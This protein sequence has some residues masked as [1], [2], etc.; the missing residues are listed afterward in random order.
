[1]IGAAQKNVTATA[2]VKLDVSAGL[3]SR[4]QSWKC[5]VRKV[6]QRAGRLLAQEG[7]L[8]PRFD[9]RVLCPIVATTPYLHEPTRLGDQGRPIK[10]AWVFRVAMC[11]LL[12]SAS[13]NE[14][15][16]QTGG[17]AS[18]C[19][20]SFKRHHA[21][22]IDGHE[23]YRQAAARVGA[24]VAQAVSGQEWTTGRCAR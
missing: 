14:I 19:A 23:P 4:C 24:L 16:N 15:G 9:Q 7:V 3:A 8:Q 21:R 18:S 10:V 17:P 11:R 13:W 12:A 20:S 6:N 22:L 1:M 5:E 2:S